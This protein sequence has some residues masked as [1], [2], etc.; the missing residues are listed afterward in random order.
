MIGWSSQQTGLPAVGELM[1][2]VVLEYLLL[3]QINCANARDQGKVLNALEKNRRNKQLMMRH[4]QVRHQATNENN[5]NRC[6]GLSS[7]RHDSHT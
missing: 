5:F 4:H 6:V 3:I 1:I 2:A 7:P